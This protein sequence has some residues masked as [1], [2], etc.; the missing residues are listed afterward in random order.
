MKNL[1]SWSGN[2]AKPSLETTIAQ[3]EKSKRKTK[4][5]RVAAAQLVPLMSSLSEDMFSARWPAGWEYRVWNDVHDQP[6][7]PA[8]RIDRALRATLLELSERSGGWAH[9]PEDEL[10]PAFIPMEE[11]L[12]KLQ[13]RKNG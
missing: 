9:L 8:H 1:N 2:R 3:V 5:S 13:V 7:D 6:D 12:E 11:W 10:D 4:D